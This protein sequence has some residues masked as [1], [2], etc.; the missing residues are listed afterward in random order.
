MA[1][2]LRAGD[3][4]LVRSGLREVHLLGV[5]TQV[6]GTLGPSRAQRVWS[7]WPP[8]TADVLNPALLRPFASAAPSR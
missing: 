8:R 4:V 1:D 2:K 5:R 3:R 7:C 6:H